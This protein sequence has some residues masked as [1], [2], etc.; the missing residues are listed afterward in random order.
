M[1]IALSDRLSYQAYII[2]AAALGAAQHHQRHRGRIATRKGKS[3]RYRIRRSVQ[4]I[5]HCLGPI[6]FR[7]AYR[8]SYE[9]FWRL[10]DLLEERIQALGA[11]VRGYNPKE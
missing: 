1:K 4:D 5:Y 9:A 10:H 3:A 11:K 6:Y 2:Q 7:R 8:M